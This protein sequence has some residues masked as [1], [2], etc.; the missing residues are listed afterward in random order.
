[1][2]LLLLVLLLL[3]LLLILLVLL[4]LLLALFLLPLIVAVEWSIKVASKGPVGA[5][6]TSRRSKDLDL[7][8]LKR[9][10]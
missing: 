10:V 6:R 4:L 7:T 2:L 8:P 3:L 9:C 5:T 1:L